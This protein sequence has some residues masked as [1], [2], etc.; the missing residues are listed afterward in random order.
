MFPLLGIRIILQ[1]PGARESFHLLHALTDPDLH[2]DVEAQT[3]SKGEHS[4]APDS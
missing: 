3:D 4:A 2:V 1:V